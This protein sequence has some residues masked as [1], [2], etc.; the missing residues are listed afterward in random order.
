MRPFITYGGILNYLEKIPADQSLW[1]GGCFVFDQ[2][3]AIGHGLE[4]CDI[5][6]CHGC[7]AP[8]SDEDR[9]S[10]KIRNR[11]VLPVLL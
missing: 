6:L 2:R 10:K 8:L 5:T 3:V 7:R 9:K 4:I 1:H 11:R